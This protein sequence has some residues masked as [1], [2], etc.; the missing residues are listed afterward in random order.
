LRNITYSFTVKMVPRGSSASADAYLTPEIKDYLRGFVKGFVDGHL[1][2]VKCD[3][4]QS[5]GGLVSHKGFSGLKGIL[6]GPAGKFSTLNFE[7]RTSL[8]V[9]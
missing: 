3:F 7:S 5:D 2:D 4:M 8:S 9:W 6:S 1:D